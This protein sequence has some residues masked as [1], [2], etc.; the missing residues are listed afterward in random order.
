MNK[1]YILLIIIGLIACN[2]S[3]TNN[4]SEG[5]FI[6]DSDFDFGVIPDSVKLLHHRFV[7]KN[8][9]SDTCYI[10]RIE[11]SCGCTNL[12]LSSNIIP[13][14]DSVHLNMEVDLGSNYS[15]FE[16][17]VSI[18]TTTYKEPL[19]IFIRASRRLPKQFISKDFPLKIS[20]NI[21]LSTPYVIFGNIKMGNIKSE[22]VNLLNTSEESINFT[23][24]IIDAPPYID[25]FYED[26]LK[27]NE[28]G[29][30]II[31][32]D[33]SKINNVWGLQ[34]YEMQV[35][36]DDCATT[37]PM[38]AI[39]VEDFKAE[40]EKPRIFIP[41][42]NYTINCSMENKADFH[43]KNIGKQV[44]CIR[45][46]SISNRIKS[47]IVSSYDIK[48]GGETILSIHLNKE[49]EDIEVGITT[50]DPIEPYKIIRIFCKY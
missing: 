4:Q 16:R 35:K 17:D 44:L 21:R 13:P 41:I 39:F 50:N 23:A 8:I 31:R 12:V 26:E 38:E 32:I 7:I 40:K 37:I 3:H 27:P 15:F 45:D 48:P 11:K 46:I 29:R 24:S 2:S 47:M 22:S 30:I 6:C 42:S 43:I 20:E 14:Y 10:K 49:Q 34:K 33:L 18:Y 28:V 25:V 36:T 5:V 19:M 9:T 1:L